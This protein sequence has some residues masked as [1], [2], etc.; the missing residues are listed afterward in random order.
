[1]LAGVVAALLVVPNGLG[2][3]A[4]ALNAPVA[5]LITDGDEVA[6]PNTEVGAPCEDWPKTDVEG[7]CGCEKAETGGAILRG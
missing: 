6:W 1:V 4:K 3:P 7:C 2:V 5:G